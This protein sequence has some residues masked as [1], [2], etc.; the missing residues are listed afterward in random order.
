MDP[1]LYAGH[2]LRAGLATAAAAGG[3]TERA[4]MR[5]TGHR[6]V[7]VLRR[8]IRAGTLWDENAA[9]FVGLMTRRGSALRSESH[10]ATT[11]GL[12]AAIWCNLELVS[13]PEL[14][15]ESSVFEHLEAFYFI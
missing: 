5:Q 11:R 2:S 1:S 14:H 4:I 13:C 8:Y 3:A 7:E 9:A 6:S 12:T 15:Y 10:S